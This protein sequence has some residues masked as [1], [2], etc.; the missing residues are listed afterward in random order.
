MTESVRVAVR[1]ALPSFR[2][3]FDGGKKPITDLEI[4]QCVIFYD[5]MALD[6]PDGALALAELR[7]MQPRDAENLI[8]EVMRERQ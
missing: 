5:G 6:G 3:Q 8:L 7:R 4:A 2:R 1:R